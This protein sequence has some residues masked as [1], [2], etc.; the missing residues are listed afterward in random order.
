MPTFLPN[1]PSAARFRIRLMQRL[2]P[3]MK[4]G[5]RTQRRSLRQCVPVSSVVPI[6]FVPVSFAGRRP[7]CEWLDLSRNP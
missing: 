5:R 7:Y 3:N 6:S 4:P 2:K 1:S